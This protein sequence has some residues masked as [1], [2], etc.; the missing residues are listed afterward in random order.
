MGFT[1]PECLSL[2]PNGIIEV[3]KGSECDANREV[4]C[5]HQSCYTVEGNECVFPF[6]YKDVVYHQCSSEDVYLPWCATEFDGTLIK[7]WGLCL[8][9]CPYIVPEVVC[10]DPPVVPQFGSR[11]STGDI[12]E[13]NYI[14]SWFTLHFIDN[15][16]G[17]FNHSHMRVTRAERDLLYQPLT[18]YDANVLKE[19]NLEF[20][21]EN[22]DSHFNDVYQIMPNNSVV[23]YRCP[24]GWVFANT[25]NISHFAYCR[26][27]T[28]TIDFNT[29]VPCIRK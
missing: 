7:A 12:L 16:D 23:E 20:I 17:S 6:T 1:R 28:W 10:L 19:N 24:V 18:P 3:K 29:S 14:S 4:L 5:E 21:A 2:T 22:K 9:D 25:N 11:N 13:Q 8:P 15:S 27:W 26:N